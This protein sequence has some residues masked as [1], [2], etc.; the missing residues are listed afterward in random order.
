MTKDCYHRYL[1]SVVIDNTPNITIN[2]KIET[3]CQSCSELNRR[4]LD[5]RKAGHL[6]HT[7]AGLNL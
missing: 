4:I 7:I 1:I 6:T 2:E 5:L 3:R